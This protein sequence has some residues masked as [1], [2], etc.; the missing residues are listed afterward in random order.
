MAASFRLAQF[1]S[2]VREK[3]DKRID[4]NLQRGRNCRVE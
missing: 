2:V 4:G 3:E 1:S